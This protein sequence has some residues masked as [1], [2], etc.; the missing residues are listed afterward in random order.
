MRPAILLTV[1]LLLSPL[2]SFCQVDSLRTLSD[3]LP[4]P[5]ESLG[6]KVDR[7][8]ASRVNQMIYV[9]V[10]LLVGSVIVKGQDSHFRGLR[11]EYLGRFDNHADNFLQYSPAAVMLALKA[12]GVQSR[13]SWGRMMTSDAFSAA[14]MASVVNILKYSTDVMRPDGSNANSSPSGHTATAFMTATMLTKEYGHKSP[15]IGIGSFAV[16]TSTGFMRMANNK[17][18]LSDV[19]TGASVG[20]LSTEVGYF[21]ADLI[22]KDRGLLVTPT[23]DTLDRF[24]RPTFFGT[25]L[26]LNIPLSDYDIDED[27]VFRT[28]SGSSAGIEGA[29]FFNP[30]VGAGCR[31]TVTNLLL[32]TN[33]DVAERNPFNSITACV[34]PYFSYPLTHRW[35]VGTKLLAGYLHYPRLHLST[36]TIDSRDGVCF[37]SGVSLTLKARQHYGVR[38][39]LDYNLQPSHSVTS[40][41]WMNTLACGISYVVMP[42]GKK[43]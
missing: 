35:L 7:L 32:I 38:F 28:S 4:R 26:G 34:G 27:N 11:N 1:S 24:S 39:F 22:F 43:K 41:E 40:A 19:L 2:N 3:S 12:A 20:I 13:S 9:G 14:T 25:Y 23:P 36:A 37:G 18:W 8:S 31:A 5:T 42:S 33:G 29:Y 17:H 15:W 30:Y 16:A 21:L 6:D 10:P